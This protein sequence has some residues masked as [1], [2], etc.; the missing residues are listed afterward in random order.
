ME[1]KYKY[2]IVFWLVFAFTFIIEYYY[3]H[4]YSTLQKVKTYA[5][6][7]GN[8]FTEIDQKINNLTSTGQLNYLL[9]SQGHM[10]DE[11]R[12]VKAVH[13]LIQDVLIFNDEFHLLDATSDRFSIS[14]I[15]S[16][17]EKTVHEKSI[18][19]SVLQEG[20][21][22]VYPA[23]DGE[24]KV[25][26][27]YIV[28]ALNAPSF[29]NQGSIFVMNVTKGNLFWNN[30]N[31]LN[32][33]DDKVLREKLR[34]TE[35]DE[36]GYRSL[37]LSRKYEVFWSYYLPGNIY[38]GFIRYAKPFYEF[39]YFYILV[40]CVLITFTVILNGNL[41]RTGKYE[42]YEKIIENNIQ[43]LSEMKKNLEFLIEGHKTESIIEVEAISSTIDQALQMEEV[44]PAFYHKPEKSRG[45]EIISDFILLD[46]L[47]TRWYKPIKRRPKI[48]NI[49]KASRLSRAAFTPELLNLMEQISKKDQVEASETKI[50]SHFPRVKD[51][52]KQ[53]KDQTV[54]D[55]KSFSDYKSIEK[56]PFAI[57]LERLYTSDDAGEELDIV[58]E[59]LK[60]KGDAD[61]LAIMFFDR[62]I[63]CYT[64]EA[65]AGLDAVWA[66]N[67]YLLTYDSVLPCLPDKINNI[68]ISDELLQNSFFR[69]R[70]PGEYLN[71]VGAIKLTTLQV[72][73]IPVRAVH[74]YWRDSL[75]CQENMDSMESALRRIDTD[76]YARWFTHV[77]PIFN[78]I[79]IQKEKEK[80]N[81][82]KSYRD[83]YNT[84]KSFTVLSDKKIDIVHVILSTVFDA[85]FREKL[86]KQ[87]KENFKN[88]ERYIVNNPNHL[89]FL[90]DETGVEFI[91]KIILELDDKAQFSVL[92]YPDFGKNLFAYL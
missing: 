76:E 81:P 5:Q 71:R 72:K 6:T 49:E 88:Y 45:E 27:G 67:F 68:I 80:I 31:F 13:P 9:W 63:G 61:G 15:T 52:E 55:K 78:K 23:I 47:E 37:D 34:A 20:Y 21:F 28:I 26:K 53:G 62:N 92:K 58:L 79:F 74:F 41:K 82:D 51:D 30:G 60:V 25:T 86:Q 90:L 39:I 48:Q 1:K 83:I 36:M 7:T 84:L 59:N 46:P 14:S 32:E 69:K 75:F 57:A 56:D 42:V 85:D 12:I 73:D 70:I 4:N 50:Q 24:S 10:A 40:S 3:I 17:L 43:T 8:L 91:E 64:I 11:L 29:I 54:Y 19:S 65:S 18:K 33:G 77:L 2:I 66:R 87:C 35:M 22:H 89:I 16:L 38:F 44:I